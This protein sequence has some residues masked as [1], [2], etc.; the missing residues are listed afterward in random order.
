MSVGLTSRDTVFGASAVPQKKK[1]PVGWAIFGLILVLGGTGFWYYFFGKKPKVVLTVALPGKAE[2][3]SG[4]GM[5][6][7]GNGEVI[8]L[9]KQELKLVGLR[10][11]S[12]KWSV[13]VPAAPTVD[14]V[15]RA[16]TN[17]RFV[18]LQQWADELNRKRL[19]LKTPAE[20]K[21]FNEEA[22][23]YQAELVA[24]RAA[25]KPG[26]A[27]AKAADSKAKGEEAKT[28]AAALEAKA[29]AAAA[30]KK[31]VEES[32][33]KLKPIITPEMQLL[34]AR[35]DRRAKDIAQLAAS[36]QAKK[37]AAKTEIQLSAVQDIERR[38]AAMTAEQKEE[39]AQ[40][41]KLQGTLEKP[42]EKKEVAAADEEEDSDEDEKSF[43]TAPAEP[44]AAAVGSDVWLVDGE[45]MMSFD[46][47]S[48]VLKS[49]VPLAGAALKAWTAAGDLYVE[50]SS[51]PVSRQITRVA[52]GAAPVSLHVPAAKIDD[53]MEGSGG[54]SAARIQAA[55]TEF[56]GPLIRA[57]IKLVEKKVNERSAIKPGSD[58][59]LVDTINSSAGNSSD[60]IQ[61]LSQLIANDG[62]RLA[63]ETKQYSD[64]STYELTL[65]RP[66][67]AAIP[68]WKGTVTG[69]VE[70]ISATNHDFVVAGTKLL[71]FN[72]SGQKAWEATLGARLPM[73]T[74]D[75][76]VENFIE[77]A[78]RI[79]FADGAFLT[80]FEA[81]SGTVLW[82]VPSIGIRKLQLDQDGKVYVHS[83]N[84][85]TESL[86]YAIDDSKELNP[87][88]MKIE[89]TDGKIA[90]QV[91]KF[92]D[93]WVSGNDVYVIRQSRNPSDIEE[94]V[95][96]PGKVRGSNVKLYKLSRSNGSPIWEWYQQRVPEFVHADRKTVGLL[97]HDELQVLHSIA[98]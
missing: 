83:L 89:P 7:A 86:T 13:K 22:T 91:E 9:S 33:V 17:A 11:R 55:R 45:H 63:G 80:A 19:N 84:L 35:I 93:L 30:A 75:E 47:G 76:N 15:L 73:A 60:E 69:H 92:E 54:E 40:L 26:D 12:V 14:A 96:D 74:D 1:F 16:S 5:W 79:Y 90:W 8:V 42:V 10:D 59:A 28:K 58:K 43:F 66:L 95:F 23:K 2:D 68:E 98:W 48:G 78:D 94:Q 72:R 97:Y 18:R 6:P 81:A 39:Q 67:D 56:F 32:A 61:A 71:V 36:A 31:A 49:D 4:D 27:T 85:P 24:T 82:R 70:V 21:A 57:D 87:I 44:F 65:R 53:F 51:G 41:A 25:M 64:E 52:Q 20:T 38:L 62:R 50:A 46:R 29:A 37:A 34:Q 88:T 3:F 77:T